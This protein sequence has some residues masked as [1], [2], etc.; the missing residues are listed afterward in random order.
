MKPTRKRKRGREKREREREKKTN[1]DL[2]S[3]DDD[4]GVGSR[5]PSGFGDHRVHYMHVHMREENRRE[6]YIVLS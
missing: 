5:G 2:R 6:I 4:H 3:D 1:S